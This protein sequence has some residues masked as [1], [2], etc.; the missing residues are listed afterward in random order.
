MTWPR[1]VVAWLFGDGAQLEASALPARSAR[2]PATSPTSAG[3]ATSCWP[4]LTTSVTTVPSRRACRR[5]DPARAP[6]PSATPRVKRDS[7]RSAL[8]PTSASRFGGVVVQQ[9]GDVRHLRVAGNHARRKND[10]RDDQ[11]RDEKSADDRDRVRQRPAE[12]RPSA[13]ADALAADARRTRRRCRDAAAA[14]GAVRCR[15]PSRE[16]RPRAADRASSRDGRSRKCS[17]CSSFSSG[18]SEHVL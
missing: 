17:I 18:S 14:R 15:A 2:Q 7:P 11:V 9:A 10:E 12:L 8:N 6:S 3:T 16:R 1:G 13:H 5:A 4:A